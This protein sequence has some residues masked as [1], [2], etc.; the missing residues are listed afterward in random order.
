MYQCSVCGKQ[1]KTKPG[2]VR[3]ELAHTS[4]F[5]CRT[6]GKQYR[7]K[8]TLLKHSDHCTV[9]R[10]F[11]CS[12]CGWT[13][14][15]LRELQA[16]HESHSVQ[17]G[18]QRR[19]AMNGNVEIRT[20]HPTGIDKFDLLKF[21][22]NVR[23]AIE[24]YLLSKVRKQAIKWYIVAQVELSREDAE[25]EIRTV[26]P[27]FRSVTYTLL[28]SDT[29]ESHDLN[30]ALQKVVIGLEKYI[31]ESSGWSLRTVKK[32]DI[33]T[34]H[35]KPLRASSYIEL[36]K[37]LQK[38]RMVLNIRNKDD[39][40]FTW[41]ILAHIHKA[42]NNADCVDNYIPYESELCMKSIDYP[43]P[44]CK[45]NQFEGQNEE[46]SINVFGFENDEIYPLRITRQKGRKHHINLLYL[47]RGDLFHYCLIRDLNGFLY[48][49][50][51]HKNK[52]YFCPYC[53]HGFIREDLMVKHIEFCGINCEQKI[54]HCS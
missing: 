41:E 11:I 37:T 1:F 35:Y 33:N 27:Y 49:T 13:F 4:L 45:V 2:H 32:L 5:T 15:T 12:K 6:C 48:R 53:L 9:Q 50:E 34:I 14:K 36:P 18:G 44:L 30:Q 54:G 3:H 39:K 31:H 47:Q 52:T 17:T 8:A 23:P 28:T 25:R 26:G 24:R 51:S 21:L 10:Q 7:R 22:A 46:L 42:N 16:H 19:S 40:C 20:I 38:S 43:V 29:F